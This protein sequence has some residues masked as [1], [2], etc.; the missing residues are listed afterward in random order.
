MKREVRFD[1]DLPKTKKL[2]INNSFDDN[3]HYLND[4]ENIDEEF[5][6]DG[7]KNPNYKHYFCSLLIIA[8]KRKGGV[9]TDGYESG[10]SDSDLDENS[11]A[12]QGDDEDEDMFSEKVEKPAAEQ[13][14]TK[15]KS[16]IK[17]LA[18]EKIVGQEWLNQES[19]DD[20]DEK[21]EK[22][23]TITPFNMDREL[24]EGNF[25]E[26][27][28]YIQKKDDQA[29]HDTW[30]NGVTKKQMKKAKG[31]QI[32]REARRQFFDSLGEKGTESKDELWSKLLSLMVPGEAVLSVKLTLYV[33]IY[34]K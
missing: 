23:V 4:N 7:L 29:M 31:M 6:E 14:T 26:T 20:E 34:S 12:Q 33:L 32:R 30:L 19:S 21:G 8:K 13:S 27:G 25:D 15:S 1:D 24:E 16:G 22:K 28:H 18:K 2:K 17:Y 5:L 10:E 3:H 9:I 11:P